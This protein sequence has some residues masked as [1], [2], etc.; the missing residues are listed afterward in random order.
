MKKL[1][2]FATLAILA[3][4]VS[5]AALEIEKETEPLGFIESF[6]EID[7]SLAVT[8]Y[9]FL[10]RIDTRT[11]RILF[12]GSFRRSAVANV[13]QSHVLTVSFGARGRISSIQTTVDQSATARITAGGVGSNYVT[14]RMQS[15]RGRGFNISVNIQGR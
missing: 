15:Q 7:G 11:N 13:V 14:I 1:M 5:G 4:Y 8:P 6:E 10:S 12:S 2:L 3:A 9:D